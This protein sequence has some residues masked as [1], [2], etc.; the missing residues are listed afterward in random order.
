[1]KSTKI[2]NLN[3]SKIIKLL[4]NNT[5]VFAFFLLFVSS[6]LLGCVLFSK[7]TGL[8]AWLFNNFFESRKSGSFLS[9]FIASFGISFLFLFAE[10]IFGTSL[11]GIAFV[12]SLIL[13]K[14]LLTGVFLCKLYSVL[15]FQ[16]ITFNIIIFIPGTCISV[17][18]LITGASKALFLSY[19]LGR[20]LFSSTGVA[21]GRVKTKKYLILFLILVALTV[22]SALIEALL[23][24]AFF[25]YFL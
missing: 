5:S 13:F 21:L 4:R 18:C 7:A 10:Y 15:G 22:L 20:L 8:S 1:M 3:Q 2:V 6:L 25:H 17:L 24:K 19:N 9:Y 16:A 11:V 23:S 14:G 12:P